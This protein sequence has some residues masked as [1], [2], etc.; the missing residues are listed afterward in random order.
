MSKYQKQILNTL[1]DKYEKSKSFIG[2][3]Q[4]TQSFTQ[5]IGLLF[6]KYE[7]DSEYETFC[8][9]NTAVDA[10]CS[11][12]F[13]A[14][15]R[16]RNGVVQSVTLNVEQL[17][18]VYCYVGRVPKTD[19]VRNLHE[20]LDKY[21]DC[22]E[23]LMSFC[24]V[25]K[26]RLAA[27]KSV[28]Y[29]KDDLSTF[30]MVLKTVAEITNVEHEIF[31]RDFSIQLFGD[32][33][34]FEG[35]R[36]RVVSLLFQYGDFPEKETLL[37]ELN[38]VKN[39]GHVYFK[40]SGSISVSG[41]TID[42]SKMSGDL[43][44]SSNMLGEI[45]SINVLGDAIVTIENLT[46]FNAFKCE[47]AFAIYLGGYHNT[48]RRN[49]I[50]RVYEQNP[51]KQYLH[52]GD[53]D[54]GGFYILQHLRRK[55]GINFIPYQM[56]IQTLKANIRYSKPLTSY[57]RQR[58]LPLSTGEFKEVVAYMLEN[59]CKLEQEALDIIAGNKR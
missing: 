4:V 24:S 52:Y 54:A 32:S 47:N 6:P 43:A 42:F 7:D 17:Q 46:T 53:I 49:F 16:R 9:I 20:L 5:K 41:Q 51:Q 59:N 25:Q 22:N 44:L 58:L 1:L 40:G 55:T 56:D 26:S 8:D 13:I 21:E 18:D 2:S 11:R 31:E 30:E 57:D 3:N 48:N 35:I 19:T 38:V 37:E 45:D 29:F 34:A 14:A 50:R 36:S 15:K 12:D 10:L 27:N 39:P 28:E 23:I 33:K